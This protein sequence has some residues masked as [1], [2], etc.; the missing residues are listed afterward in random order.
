MSVEVKVNDWGGG[1]VML[2][3][4]DPLT[5]RRKAKSPRAAA[6]LVG[7]P[8]PSNRQRDLDRLAAVLQDRLNSADFREPSAITWADFRRKWEAQYTSHRKGKP[9][10]AKGRAATITAF[11]HLERVM[12][13]DKLARLTT[14]YFSALC[15]R[16]RAEGMKD[17]T[18]GCV[19][20]HLSA[21]LHWAVRMKLLASV[22]EFDRPEAGGMKGRPITLEEHE[23]MVLAVPKVR[24]RD[25]PAWADYLTGL[26][27]SGLRLEESR[28]LSWDEDAPFR[29]DLSGSRPKFR[30]DGSAQKSG[31]DEL[32]PMA[33]DLA[34]WI[35]QT[36][37]D[38]RRGR[39]FKL[40][41]LRTGQPLGNRAIG[42]TVCE[43][44]ETAGVVVNKAEAKYASAH[45]YRRAFGTR[46]AKRVMPA[47]LQRLMRHAN[48]QTTMKFY[49]DVDSD[50]VAEVLWENHRQAQS[51]SRSP[52][53][54]HTPPA[55]SILNSGPATGRENVSTDL[56][57]NCGHN[58][59]SE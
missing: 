4:P 11:N 28:I 13:P 57:S 41:D 35:L 37:A 8:P 48:I 20:R 56:Q 30:I 15:A 9:L 32:L 39:V 54:V 19:L 40:N 23:R 24:P 55:R 51:P 16:L 42:G 1:R 52:H 17:S 53:S 26:W 29:I 46:W 2:T 12:R 5:G 18:L 49:A 34:E 10:S 58:E 38:E 44:G 27:L 6:K 25:A 21:A 59:P 36:S 3:W 31:K 7:M 22:P 14:P 45:D 33:P 43:I 47:V 50:A